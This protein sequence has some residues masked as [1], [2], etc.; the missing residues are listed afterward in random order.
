VEPIKVTLTASAAPGSRF[1][2]WDF[3]GRDCNNSISCE[4]TVDKDMVVGAEFQHTD[5]DDDAIVVMLKTGNGFGTVKS[6]PAGVDCGATCFGEFEPDAEITLTATADAGSTFIR[7]EGACSGI[8]PSCTLRASNVVF[9]RAEF[10]LN[11]GSGSNFLFIN[12]TGDGRGTVSSTPNGIECGFDCVAEFN[13]GTEVTL[14]ASPKP[15]SVFKGWD[16]ACDIAT[17]SACRVTMSAMRW[18]RAEFAPRG[19]SPAGPVLGALRIAPKARVAKPGKP[20]VFKAK[21]KNTGRSVAK[22]VRI[23]VKAPG[24]LIRVKR[25][26][27]V[28]SLAA[29]RTAKATF[30]AKVSKKVKRSKKVKLTFTATGTG[31]GRNVA[32]KKARATLKVKQA[33]PV[34]RTGKPGRS[35]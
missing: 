20:A 3:D 34:R 5:D 35:H 6:G 2:R 8:V 31:T 22:A 19:A 12:K 17:G 14:T 1:V 30:K 10:E 32:R 11:A 4:V 7:W 27:K 23:C 18:V 15:G 13:R 21:V 25:C 26:V 9:V 28:G 33:A 29:G 16:G 24:G